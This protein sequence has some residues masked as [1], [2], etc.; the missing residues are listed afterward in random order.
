[1]HGEEDHRCPIEQAEQ[2]FVALKRQGKTAEFVRFPGGSH[3]FRNE[4]H[5]KLR[6]EYLQRMVDWFGRYLG[7]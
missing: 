7:G 6:V 4:G 3:G 5:P 1:M 2:F